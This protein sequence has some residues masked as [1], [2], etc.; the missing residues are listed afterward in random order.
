[1]VAVERLRLL[2]THHRGLMSELEMT[3]LVEEMREVVRMRLEAVEKRMRRLRMDPGFEGEQV[4][5]D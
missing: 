5:A 2:T 4:V 3:N 1:M